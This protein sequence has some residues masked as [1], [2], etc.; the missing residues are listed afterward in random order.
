M[1][2]LELDEI[3]FQDSNVR[4]II[5]K[6]LPK[7]I[8]EGLV[9]GAVEKD[10][11]F[12]PE[13]LTLQLQKNQIIALEKNGIVKL[14]QLARVSIKNVDDYL[15]Q[16]L[17]NEN[18]FTILAEHVILKSY[19]VN[20]ATEIEGAI[21]KDGFV[22]LGSLT[23]FG[24]SNDSPD[25]I[26]ISQTSIRLANEMLS[27]IVI[28]SIYLQEPEKKNRKT[29][30]PNYLVT[31]DLLTEIKTTV[32]D[33]LI[34]PLARSNASQAI[35]NSEIFAF[36]E[37]DNLMRDELL[38][39]LPQFDQRTIT[40][41]LLEKFNRKHT[42]SKA[43]SPQLLR[44]FGTKLGPELI[45][46]YESTLMGETHSLFNKGKKDALILLLINLRGILDISITEKKLAAKFYVEFQDTLYDQAK[47][48]L[49]VPLETAN[50]D[51]E[52][53]EKYLISEIENQEMEISL[54]EALSAR[55][56][57]IIK[58]LERA[59]KRI[60]DI[61][62]ASY[63]LHLA[64]VI[65][66]AKILRL[67]GQYGT[68]NITGKYAPKVLKNLEKRLD[69]GELLSLLHALKKKEVT[70]ETLNSAKELAINL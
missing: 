58:G 32:E 37:D 52:D 16:H 29:I 38:R 63:A 19:S 10:Q 43:L 49:Y 69:V 9:K 28:Q 45:E 67:D 7:A 39:M 27:D 65:I 34:T 66:H 31:Q 11:T 21:R 55:Q 2:A 48:P 13:A 57:I 59:L 17:G 23:F 4:S 40:G 30:L 1:S 5:L 33:V 61:N 41:Y 8:K 54:E 12:V 60:T 25:R 36:I 35:S 42:D 3:L 44:Y 64:T 15:T 68:L 6:A 24:V 51:M 53:L 22:D 14:S 18:P 50:L 20:I 47:G 70:L 62:E 56:E 46:I 26:T